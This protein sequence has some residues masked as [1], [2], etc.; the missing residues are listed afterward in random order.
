VH[1]DT[2]NPVQG[3]A[4]VS[5]TFPADVTLH[6]LEIRIEAIQLSPY[7]AGPSAHRFRTWTRPL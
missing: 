1:H 5:G 6:R 3:A 4:P 7:H 2:V